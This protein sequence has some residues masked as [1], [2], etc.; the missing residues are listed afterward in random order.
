[1]PKKAKNEKQGSESPST[2][3]TTL[4]KLF[5]LTPIRIQQLANEGVT[6]KSARGRYELWPSIKNY[7]KYLQE[8]KINQWTT[9]EENPTEL[10]KH[11][12]RRTKEE[13]DKLE[14]Q[15]AKT[16]GELVPINEVIR[17]FQGFASEIRTTILN[18]EVT[19]ETKNKTLLMLKNAGEKLR[20]EDFN[21][22]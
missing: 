22:E 15:N 13:A 5:N 4:S 1:M 14:L 2:D 7:I 3:V 19:E 6:V 9:D 18:S 21:D 11:Q 8:R 17:Y 20:D 10:K 12:L 16:R